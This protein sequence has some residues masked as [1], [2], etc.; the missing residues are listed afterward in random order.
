MQNFALFAEHRELHTRLEAL[1]TE[2]E[3]RKR[4]YRDA[5][6]DSRIGHTP[7]ILREQRQAEI[8]ALQEFEGF[9]SDES[10]KEDHKYI[11]SDTKRQWEPKLNVLPSPPL[12]ESSPLN[13]LNTK[14]RQDE[15]LSQQARQKRRR[16]VQINDV[17]VVP[18]K[19][20]RTP[21]TGYHER[22]LP[23]QARQR[24]RIVQINDV[25]VVAKKRRKRP[26]TDYHDEMLPQQARQ[27]RR[28][29]VQ[30]NNVKMVAKKRGGRVRGQANQSDSVWQGRLRP[31]GGL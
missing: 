2:Q 26:T 5:A 12:S 24:Q 23:Q 1:A 31:R 3:C 19:R 20:R 21:T 6:D 29:I 4:K 13:T 15:E 11:P 14:K 9:T 30:I 25:E 17:E 16:I 10:D 27:R 22:E 28:C 8:A 7:E 18:K